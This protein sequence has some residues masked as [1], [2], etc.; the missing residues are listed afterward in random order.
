MKNKLKALTN[1][2]NEFGLSPQDIVQYWIESGELSEKSKLINS[3]EDIRNKTN[4]Y[5]Y[6]FANGQFSPDPNAHKA[7]MGVVG[8]INAPDG[9]KIYIVMPKQY[10]CVF[11]SAD[12]DVRGTDCYNGLAN[13]QTLLLYAKEHKIVIPPVIHCHG[14]P[15]LSGI[16]RPFLPAKEQAEELAMN[17]YG[18]RCALE[19]IGGTFDGYIWTSTQFV[20]NNVWVI[21]TKYGLADIRSVN[22]KANT[23][24]IM[25]L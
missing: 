13:S 24:A 6:Y 14:L 20:A 18:I 1:M 3:T 4:L 19:K 21:N 22:L 12:I 10:N 15:K 7:C 17:N 16:E 23:T 25:V 5:W 8:W 9:N 11:S 2:V